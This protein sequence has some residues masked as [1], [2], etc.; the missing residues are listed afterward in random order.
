M[1]TSRRDFV[2]GA[3]L[4]GAAFAFPG[5][6]WLDATERRGAPE[7]FRPLPPAAQ[8]DEAYW[9]MV[10]SQFLISTRGIYF[11]TGTVGASPRTVLDAVVKHM[12]AFET[13]FDAEGVDVEALRR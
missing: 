10:R 7:P 2:R 8:D 6:E 3:A 4:A 12:T 9:R 5:A 11:N 13:V 1:T